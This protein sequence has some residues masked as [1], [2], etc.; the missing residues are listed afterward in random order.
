MPSHPGTAGVPNQS[1]L[2]HGVGEGDMSH[3]AASAANTTGQPIVPP[4]VDNIPG[5]A[6]IQRGG[7]LPNPVVSSMLGNNPSGPGGRAS[8]LSSSQASRSCSNMEN[9]RKGT[10]WLAYPSGSC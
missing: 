7:S 3:Y 9:E 6:Q 8:S 4:L 1:Q 5:G 2:H 10:N